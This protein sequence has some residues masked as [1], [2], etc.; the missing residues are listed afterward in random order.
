MIRAILLLAAVAAFSQPAAEA[1]YPK[2]RPQDLAVPFTGKG[3]SADWLG[4]WKIVGGDDDGVVWRIFP[5][6]SPACRSITAGRTSCFM[7]RPPGYSVD[8]A[9]SITLKGR[10]VVLRMTYRPRPNSLGCFHDDAYN[11]R[12]TARLLSIVK[13]SDHSCFWEPSAHFPIR[14]RRVG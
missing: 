3:V 11:Y 2:P 7:I 12:L 9:G 6:K 13:G 5:R 4:R 1:A 10:R 8:W 14:L